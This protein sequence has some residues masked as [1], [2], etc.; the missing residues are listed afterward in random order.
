MKVQNNT[1]NYKKLINMYVKLL[2]CQKTSWYVKSL[3][4]AIQSCSVDKEKRHR[5]SFDIVLMIV[6]FLSTMHQ[7]I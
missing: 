6:Q 1:N 7:N 2:R 4:R 5:D 3:E